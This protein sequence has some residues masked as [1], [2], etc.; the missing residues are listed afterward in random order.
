MDT[1]WKVSSLKPGY[2]S[3]L[4]SMEAIFQAEKKGKYPS[5]TQLVDR[6]SPDG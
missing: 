1:L 4:L 5:I 2:Q 3:V 6:L